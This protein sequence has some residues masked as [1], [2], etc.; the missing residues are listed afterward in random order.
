VSTSTSP[1]AD[2][3]RILSELVAF[4][5]DV[6]EGEERPIAEHL[7]AIL[8]A[9]G[10]DEVTITDVPRA[11]GKPSSSVYA[12]FG[13]PRLLVNA[14]LDTVPPNADWSSDPF[15]P[16]IEGGRLYALGAADT[17]GAAAAILAALA[18]ARPKDTA[19]LFSGD[20]EFS[21]VSMRAFLASAQH[22]G[23]E[24]AVVCEPTNLRAGTRHRGIASF[25]VDVTGPGGHSSRADREPSP[26]AILSRLGVALDDWARARRDA[27]PKGFEGMCVNLAKLDGGVAFN[28]IPA[29]AR[30]VVSLRPPPGADTKAIRAELEAMAQS[31]APGATLRFTRD[32]APFATG[33][34]ASFEPLLGDAAGAPIDLGFWTE[35]ALL[36]ASGI[37]AVVLGPGDIAQAHGPDEW[38]TIDELHRAR[39]VF[40]AMF[41][42]RDA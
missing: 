33:D 4:R 10:A 30:L 42:R 18:D 24:R 8:R 23:I 40:R 34:L 27:G 6:D 20:E 29:H 36:V 38:V 26:I 12:R 17:K 3:V 32:N 35:A 22:A 16:R 13:T 9:R 37:D 14:H 31:V 41:E 15:V 11:S 7:A 28:V 1:S 25:E 39:D 5:S 2:P 19:I 21:S